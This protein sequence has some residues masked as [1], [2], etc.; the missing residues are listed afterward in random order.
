M[1]WLTSGAAVL[2]TLVLGAPAAS[3]AVHV[4]QTV[5]RSPGDRSSSRLVLPLVRITATDAGGDDLRWNLTETGVTVDDAAG[6]LPGAGCV[7]V[8]AN[9]VWCAAVADATT[10]TNLS[11]TLGAG[12]DHALA[13]SAST[14]GDVEVDGGGGDDVLDATGL[15]STR[16]DSFHLTGPLRG[17]VDLRGGD[18]DDTL[19][20]SPGSDTLA[21]GP[22]HDDLRG[23]A[24]TDIADDENADEPVV[25]SLQD[26]RATSDGQGSSDVLTGVEGVVGGRAGDELH[27]GSG[28]DGLFGGPGPD[29][30]YGGAGDDVLAGEQTFHVVPLVPADD[31][32]HGE[33]GN[34]VLIGQG[35]ADRFDGGAGD[36]TLLGYLPAAGQS[37]VCGTG[38]D[39]VTE[40][41]TPRIAADCEQYDEFLGGANAATVT[42]PGPWTF[43]L[44]TVCDGIVARECPISIEIRALPAPGH[45]LG[46]LLAGHAT[47]LRAGRRTTIGATVPPRYRLSR[48]AVQ[49]R[50]R[51]PPFEV[52]PATITL[53]WDA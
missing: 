37:A 45:R 34:D 9:T 6:A 51:F 38:H 3:A 31:E 19:L 15:P 27:G 23:G 35:G 33:A 14:P 8:D 10:A 24:G 44:A 49:I 52:S 36:D 16:S 2:T 50:I 32:L 42:R 28:D 25:A 46:R 7:A 39:R 20:G 13:S 4:D 48:A 5:T 47:R 12:N 18:G 26:G 22:G 11:V 1:R 41:W 29:R 30:L 43:A 17:R 53:T 21:G 40:L